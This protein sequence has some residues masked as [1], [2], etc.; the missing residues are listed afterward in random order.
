MR[1]RMHSAITNLNLKRCLQLCKHFPKRFATPTET[2]SASATDTHCRAYFNLTHKTFSK[3][4]LILCIL[5]YQTEIRCCAIN[6]VSLHLAEYLP[7]WKMFQKIVALIKKKL[8]CLCPR[9]QC[10]L[11]RSGVPHSQRG[12]SSTAV[13]SAF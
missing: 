8:R 4:N 1:N 5:L 3:W 12:G 10:Q 7:Q 11:L 13:I 2:M 6:I 9:S